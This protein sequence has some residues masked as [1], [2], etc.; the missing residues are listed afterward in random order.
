MNRDPETVNAEEFIAKKGLQAKG[1]KVSALDVNKV[2]FVEPIHKPEDEVKP[3]ESEAENLAGEIDNS[4]VDDPIDIEL[5]EATQ[6][7]LF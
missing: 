3:E 4:D 1:K 7:T 5:D 6:L 2:H